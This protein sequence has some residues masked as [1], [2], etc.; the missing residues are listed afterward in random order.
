MELDTST[1]RHFLELQLVVTGVVAGAW[2]ALYRPLLS[3]DHYRWWAWGWTVFLVYLISVRVDVSYPEQSPTELLQGPAGLAEAFCF[4]VGAEVLR[5]GKALDERWCWTWLGIVIALG[6]IIGS[7]EFLLQDGRLSMTVGV[8]ARAP[9]LAPALLYCGWALTVHHRH[10]RR[11]GVWLAASG[12]V[13]YGLNMCIYSVA[14]AGEAW[15]ILSGSELGYWRLE[16]MFFSGFFVIDI[17]AEAA[18]GVGAIM[19]LVEELRHMYAL[20]QRSQRQ[21]QA[22]FGESVDAILVADGAF[23]ILAA[24]EAAQR[25][26]GFDESTLQTMTINDLIPEFDRNRL[27]TSKVLASIEGTRIETNCIGRSGRRTGVELSLSMYSVEDEQYIQAILRDVEERRSLIAQLE[28]QATHV[29]LTD[30]PNRQYMKQEI[31]RSLALQ[32]RGEAQPALLFLDLDNFKPVNDR[33]GH[34]VGDQ[35]LVTIAQRLRETVRSTDLVGHLGGDEF[36]VLLQSCK[37]A[38]ELRNL[39]ERISARLRE[40][41]LIGRQRVVIS[42]SIGGV[43][44]SSQD[45][46]DAIIDRADKAMYRS[47]SSAP[48]AGAVFIAN[49]T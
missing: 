9:F 30:L 45:T 24:N 37:S 26:L 46:V 36:I 14:A 21:F 44:A 40:P 7:I 12:F 38:A 3:K 32:L 28:H 1:L 22:L 42:A 29:P 8:L 27:P 35:V 33:F 4:V 43:R 5:R 18:I 13:L 39:G 19:I 41:F 47:K 16:L 25:M 49:A 2:W 17:I 6:I 31:Q 20:S 15:S 48:D 10:E 23:R 34:A 11:V